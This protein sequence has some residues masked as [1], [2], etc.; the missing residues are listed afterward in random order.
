MN[1]TLVHAKEGLMHSFFSQVQLFRGPSFT[2]GLLS[3]AGTSFSLSGML[4]MD[5]KRKGFMEQGL[6]D[7]S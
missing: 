7:S 4:V 2:P 6:R 3:M 1:V 5:A